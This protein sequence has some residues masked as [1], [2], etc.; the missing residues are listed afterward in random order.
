VIAPDQGPA[1]GH[2]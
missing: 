1:T 2:R